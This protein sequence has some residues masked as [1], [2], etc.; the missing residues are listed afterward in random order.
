MRPASLCKLK[1]KVSD[2]GLSYLKTVLYLSILICTSPEC[3]DEICTGLRCCSNH[4]EVLKWRTSAISGELSCPATGR[5]ENVF[6]CV[7]D[8]SLYIKK[9]AEMGAFFF[10]YISGQIFTWFWCYIV[11]H[12]LLLCVYKG[13]I[14]VLIFKSFSFFFFVFFFCFF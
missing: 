9:I 11:Q 8:F 7:F 6:M 12:A 5:F 13:N 4:C 14:P 10:Q 1:V 3:L 2:E